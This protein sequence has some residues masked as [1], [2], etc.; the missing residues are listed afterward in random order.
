M[1]VEIHKSETECMK[2][3]TEKQFVLVR[4]KGTEQKCCVVSK[5]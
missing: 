2:Q 1:C 5:L 4:T 3:H